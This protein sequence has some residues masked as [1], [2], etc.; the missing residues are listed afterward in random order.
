[1]C[2]GC[3]LLD[4]YCEGRVFGCAAVICLEREERGEHTSDAR[5]HVG[6]LQ[7]KKTFSVLAF[8]S[9]HI[10]GDTCLEDELSF[11]AIVYVKVQRVIGANESEREC[12]LQLQ[13]QGSLRM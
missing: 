4:F 8:I 5:F 11:C 13:Q 9:F 1:M 12:A 3:V 6:Y 7:C 2:E 10:Y